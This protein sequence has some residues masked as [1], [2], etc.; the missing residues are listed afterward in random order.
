M[1][2]KP[3]DPTLKTLVEVGPNDWPILAQTPPGP[4]TIVDAD[5]GTVSAAADK[6]LR[7][8]ATTPYLLHLE[9][10]AGHD[11]ATLPELLH[12]RNTLLRHRHRLPVCTVVVLLKPDSDSPVLTGQ[13]QIGLPDEA[14]YLIFRYRVIRVWQIPPQTLLAGGIGTLPLA[15][16]GAVTEHD[17]PDIIELMEERVRASGARRLADLVWAA[18][19]VLLGSRVST[20]EARTLLRRV[21]P[22]EESVTYQWMLQQGRD[23]GIALGHEEGRAQGRAEEARRLLRLQGEHRFGPL[24]DKTAVVLEGLSDINRLEQLAIRLP[25]CSSWKELLG[26]SSRKPGRRRSGS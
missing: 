10:Q 7:V 21:W 1:A 15:P 23:Q 3:Y 14:P 22:M 13:W 20:E 17:L 26:R 2:A 12:L 18:T 24:D 8:A 4:A 9:F 6:V 16:L 25:D 11:A 5:I 19:F